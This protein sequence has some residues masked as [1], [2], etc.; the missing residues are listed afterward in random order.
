M[1]DYAEKTSEVGERDLFTLFPVVLTP[2][3]V[4]IKFPMGRKGAYTVL[5]ANSLSTKQCLYYAFGH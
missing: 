2:S 3:R 4:L 5:I 1:L